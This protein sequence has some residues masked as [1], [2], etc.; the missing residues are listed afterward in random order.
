MHFTIDT[1]KFKDAIPYVSKYVGKAKK[2][3]S[4]YIGLQFFICSGKLTLIGFDG[5]SGIRYEMG[6]VEMDDFSATIEYATFDQVV[7]FTDAHEMTFYF[8]DTKLKL[9][10]GKSKYNFK[11]LPITYD[12]C[13]SYVTDGDSWLQ[14]SPAEM[15]KMFKYTS[16]YSS[17]DENMYFLR[18]IYYDGNFA[19][20][21]AKSV[22]IYPFKD[23]INKGYILPKQTYERI[24]AFPNKDKVFSFYDSGSAIV[25]KTEG[26]ECFTQALTGKFPNYKQVLDKSVNNTLFIEVPTKVLANAC[27]RLVPFNDP[28]ELHKANVI[29]SPQTITLSTCTAEK[30][31]EGIEEIALV[32][33]NVTKDVGFILNLKKLL[34]IMA[35]ATT[36]TVKIT[37]Q[38]N[39]S[40]PIKFETDEKACVFDCVI[41][42]RTVA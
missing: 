16:H 6:N 5:S 3:P 9:I 25:Y 30:D 8:E 2:S 23:A 10:C 19:S 39:L 26:I 33:T 24:I 35:T 38:E 29:I 14:I 40:T 34:V 42:T 4:T 15:N 18:G 12:T 22:C 11:Y 17:T 7:L 20:T 32:S 36:E 27:E 31:R 1:Q 37:F 21:D 13:F 28:K 41:K